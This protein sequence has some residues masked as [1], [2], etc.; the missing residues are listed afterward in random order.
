MC[1]VI[2]GNSTCLEL[3]AS[4]PLHLFVVLALAVDPAW[5]NRLTKLYR[6]RKCFNLNSQPSLRKA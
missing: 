1:R 4:N 3:N 5:T 2:V 6:I